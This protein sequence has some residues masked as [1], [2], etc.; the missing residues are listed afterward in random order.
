MDF[1]RFNVNISIE[2]DDI[3]SRLLYSSNL[4]PQNIKQLYST[5]W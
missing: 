2:G 1:S 3:L 5:F 4:M